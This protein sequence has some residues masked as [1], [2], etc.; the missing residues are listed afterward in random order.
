V[1][2]RSEKI[3]GDRVSVILVNTTFN[4]AEPRLSQV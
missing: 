4:G 3:S 1:E 2:K